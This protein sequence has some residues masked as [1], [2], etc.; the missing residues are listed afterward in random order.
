MQTRLAGISAQLALGGTIARRDI[1]L[2]RPGEPY[3]LHGTVT[4][5]IPTEDSEQVLLLLVIPAGTL[6]DFHD[7]DCPERGTVLWG[8]VE[9]NG[10]RY[11]FMQQYRFGSFEAH[12]FRAWSDSGVLLEFPP[13]EK[14]RSAR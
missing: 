1:A 11:A 14:P 5:R 12:A 6:L 3:H 9:V 7:H 13:N 10:A 4:Y 8:D 2:I